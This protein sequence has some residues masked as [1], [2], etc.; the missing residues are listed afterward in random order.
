MQLAQQAGAE[1]DIKK[2][3]ESLREKFNLPQ[4]KNTPQ[5]ELAKQ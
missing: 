5:Q 3:V 1:I 4:M 2:E